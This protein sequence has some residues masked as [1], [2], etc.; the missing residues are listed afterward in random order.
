MS[1]Y[2]NLLICGDFNIPCNNVIDT[3]VS[4][5]L[6]LLQ[7]K[8]LCQLTKTSTHVQENI[9]DL[10]VTNNDSCFIGTSVEIDYDFSSDHYPVHYKFYLK[11]DNIYSE[12]QLKERKL[13]RHYQLFNM[14]L[15]R[16]DLKMTALCNEISYSGLC[17]DDCLNLYNRTLINLIN[18]HCPLLDCNRPQWFKSNL[19]QLKRKKKKN[20]KNF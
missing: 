13:T 19:R 20:G 8:N 6:Q 1:Q 18:Q 17:D 10:I 2:D 5:F 14:E 9:L 12:V 7:T 4:E 11:K 15:F 16:N 3:Q